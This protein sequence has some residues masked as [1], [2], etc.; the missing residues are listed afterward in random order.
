[1]SLIKSFVIAVNKMSINFVNLFF[2]LNII[3]IEKI[4]IYFKNSFISD[5]ICLIT[6]TKRHQIFLHFDFLYLK[7]SNKRQK[8]E[9]LLPQS[10][11]VQI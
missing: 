9:F 6:D 8:F 1:M 7:Y 11:D 4:I 5:K 3:I 10:L 2:T